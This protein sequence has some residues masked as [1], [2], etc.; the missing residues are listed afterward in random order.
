M[1]TVT[2]G[3]TQYKRAVEG[4]KNSTNKYVGESSKQFFPAKPHYC[5]TFF[6]SIPKN[7]KTMSPSR[8]GLKRGRQ[9]RM[10]IQEMYMEI[11]QVLRNFNDKTL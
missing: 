2:S 11:N 3:Q 1:S 10:K 7:I 8:T 4:G 5:D 6:V 9:K